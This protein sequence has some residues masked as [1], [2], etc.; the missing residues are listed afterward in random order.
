MALFLTTPWKFALDFPLAQ[1]YS[2]GQLKRQKRRITNAILR[3]YPLETIRDE[4]A[5]Q[6]IAGTRSRAG[7]F[8]NTCVTSGEPT[9]RA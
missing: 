1:P 9:A 8:G 5:E 6:A 4:S 7:T 2:N 3:S